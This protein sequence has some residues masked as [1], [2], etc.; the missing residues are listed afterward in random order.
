MKKQLV[1]LLACLLWWAS[2]A[3]A[4]TNL[5]AAYSAMGFNPAAPGNAVV[6]LFSDPHMSLDPGNGWITTNLD[7][8]LV[9]NVNVMVPPPAKIL[10]NGDE[11]SWYSTCPGQLP[12]WT[13]AR[14]YGSNEMAL[15]L[16]AVQAF[17]NIAQTNILWVPGNHDQ[18]PRET[19]AE[20]FCQMFPKM[21]PY[22]LFDLAGVRFFLLNGGNMGYLSESEQHWLKQQVALTSPTQT[23]AVL[24]H[25]PPYGVN[26]GNSVMLQE[27]FRDWPT[28]WWTFS[29]H[30][31]YYS[32]QVYDIGR[33]NV[34]L[35]CVGS[36]NT[37]TFNGQTTNP[38]FMVLC[39][40]NGIAGRVYY[41]FLNGSFDV[42]EQ[43]DWQHPAHFTPNFGEVPG[44]LWRREKVP[45][46]GT[47][48]P[49]VIKAVFAYD[50]GYYYAYTSELQWALPLGRYG[51]QATHF[52]LN[53]G[54]DPTIATV[55]FSADHTNWIQVPA[56]G[57][58]NA[59]YYYPIPDQIA[60]LATGYARFY[61]A[62]GSDNFVYGWGLATANPPPWTTFP[63]L[64]PL[65]DQ[66]AVAG[67]L[68]TITNLTVAPYAPPDVLK[69]SLLSA[70]VGATVDQ[71]SGLFSWE[72]PIADSPATTIVTVKVSDN[73][74]VPMCA[75]QQFFISF[76]R[77]VNTIIVSPQWTSGQY[78]FTVSGD[79][80]LV[81]TVSAS[82]NL[83]DW[84]LLSTNH[85]PN[86]P[87]QITDPD[88]T[89]FPYRF[90]RVAVAPWTGVV[91]NVD[92][93]VPPPPP[94]FVWDSDAT[95]F[96]A[97]AG[98]AIT[99]NKAVPTALN[100]L[101]QSAKA[102]GWWTNCDA[103]YPFVGA[104]AAAHSLNLKS[105]N[106]C[107]LWHGAVSHNANGVTGDG[108]TGYGDTQFNPSV[109]NAQFQLTSAH[110]FAYNATRALPEW[111]PLLGCWMLD[112]SSWAVL[113]AVGFVVG[114]LNEPVFAQIAVFAADMRGPLLVSRTGPAAEFLAVGS[115][116]GS[117]TNA[118]S[119]LP[120]ANLGV[121][122]AIHNGGSVNG[123]CAA[124]L[125][126][127]T[128]GGGLT[129]EQWVVLRQDWDQFQAALGRKV[130]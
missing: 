107:I 102:H 39:L 115:S 106:Y 89:N 73:G 62:S 130:L 117:A 21:P 121:L 129:A 24:I 47:T 128:I 51:N 88:A 53:T 22:Q 44:L 38:G 76:W 27:C 55:S 42:V 23:V 122:A 71:Y 119:S 81:Y 13:A 52:L 91:T 108:S 80:G 87:F 92:T 30:G 68:F 33:S 110:L 41:H 1:L 69:F 90:Y 99:T 95:N 54:I 40:S 10:V 100:T 45:P 29:G 9:N 96:L 11:T 60:G 18:D 12:N 4:Y 78:K 109:A 72:P 15:W 3:Q 25:Q 64:V 61:D 101:V 2:D 59:I 58:T 83:L 93:N 17:T 37:N 127:A 94:P 63:Q 111:C 43:P 14:T 67:R 66:S 123:Y 112:Y 118:T 6:V 7:P 103:I 8:R 124:N 82:T 75:T 114:G 48:L 86:L 28:R 104:T 126:G 98:I 46:P 84:T 32:Q 26:R 31:H 70:P 35:S 85:P 16:P 19:N 50:A 113:R 120:N 74:T 97:Q 116:A 79:I 57:P 56:C 20:L 125:R 5:A 77:P 36:V 105:T 49:E 34:T 65:A